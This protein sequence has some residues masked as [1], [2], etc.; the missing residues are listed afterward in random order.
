MYYAVP[1]FHIKIDKKNQY[2][3]YIKKTIFEVNKDYYFEGSALS[4]IDTKYNRFL[5]NINFENLKAIIY[6]DTDN[7]TKLEY[8][9]ILDD[10]Q[11]KIMTMNKNDICYI[12]ERSTKSKNK[13]DVGNWYLIKLDYQKGN[14]INCIIEKIQEEKNNN[15]N[16]KEELIIGDNNNKSINDYDN[17]DYDIESID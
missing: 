2:E 16:N 14:E 3:F 10:S 6:C 17:I 13:D 11:N 5:F 9:E 1:D 12:S 8:D 7:I 4:R 15:D